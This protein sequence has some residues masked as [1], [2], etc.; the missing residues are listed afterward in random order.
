MA[1]AISNIV[2]DRTGNFYR[3]E[4]MIEVV[5]ILPKLEK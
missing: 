1:I 4:A 3:L 2:P 5:K